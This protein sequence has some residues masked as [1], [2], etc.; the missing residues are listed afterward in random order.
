[1]Y[2]VGEALAI[3][4]VFLPSLLNFEATWLL[5]FWKQGKMGKVKGRQLFPV[6]REDSGFASVCEGCPAQAASVAG[7]FYWKGKYCVV[8]T[9]MCSCCG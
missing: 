3:R 7:N 9:L 8:S 1:M 2:A 5:Y 6:G 4:Q